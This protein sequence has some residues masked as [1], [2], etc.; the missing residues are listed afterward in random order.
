MP[1]QAEISRTN[2]SCFLFLIDQSSSMADPYAGSESG[3][4]KADELATIMNRWLSNL[5][6]TC[7]KDE[8]VRDYFD[9]GV[10][11]YGTSV[12][13][14]L[15]GALAGQALLSVSQIA[16]APIRVEDRLRKVPDGAG[17]LVE[18]PVKFPV[19]LEPTAGNGT[20]MCQALQ[21]AHAL[22]SQWIS[23]HPNAFPPIVF[24][25]TDG[26]AN[27]GDPLGPAGVLHTLTTS[28]GNVLLF[29]IHLSSRPDARIDFPGRDASLP[30]DFA[31]RL[32]QMSSTLLP[33][34]QEIAR[35]EGFSIANDGRGFLFQADAAV[36]IQ[37]L[38]IG[39]QLAKNLR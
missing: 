4:S 32:F 15:G 33:Y 23:R 2:P 8:G 21:S 26:E 29:N 24:N 31:R 34:M 5:V 1:Y 35:Q 28:D 18:L 9:V 10:I 39:T 25:I 17:G 38:E 22:L 30:D 16:D 12:G 3:R 13:P 11:G 6:I 37:F 19:W 27:D 14:A 36:V 7:S 20:P